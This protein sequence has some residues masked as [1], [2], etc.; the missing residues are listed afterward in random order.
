MKL[1]MNTRGRFSASDVHPS[2][3][4]SLS[5]AVFFFSFE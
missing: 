5:E 1:G 4:G 3:A 2:V